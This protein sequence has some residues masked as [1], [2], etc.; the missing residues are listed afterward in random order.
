MEGMSFIITVLQKHVI[1]FR[2]QAIYNR[3][4]DKKTL[5]IKN[6]NAVNISLQML[7]DYEKEVTKLN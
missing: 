1:N 6:N 3:I 5:E 2:Y 4:T 7:G